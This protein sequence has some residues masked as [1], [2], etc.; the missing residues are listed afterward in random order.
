MREMIE[1]WLKEKLPQGSGFSLRDIEFKKNYVVAYMDYHVMN[2][3]GY[4]IGY[5]DFS[6][7]IPYTYPDE[8]FKVVIH[9]KRSHY[10]TRKYLLRE[11]IEDTIALSLEED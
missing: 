5:V 1:K 3:M 9:G 7:R 6:V 10:L 4:Y 11:F 8:D 2:D